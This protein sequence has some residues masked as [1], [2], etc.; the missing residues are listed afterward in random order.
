[1]PTVH[2]DLIHVDQTDRTETNR[3]SDRLPFARSQ[4]ICVL[5]QPVIHHNEFVADHAEP[6]DGSFDRCQHAQRVASPERTIC[7]AYSNVLV[8]YD[9]H[10]TNYIESEPIYQQT[11]LI[12]PEFEHQAYIGNENLIFEYSMPMKESLVSKNQVDQNY[13]KDAPLLDSLVH[14]HPAIFHLSSVNV[15]QPSN[16]HQ[17]ETTSNNDAY[18]SAI[19]P[20]VGNEMARPTVGYLASF[21]STCR[22]AMV[23][24]VKYFL[25]IVSHVE[26]M[27]LF[28]YAKKKN[29]YT[30]INTSVFKTTDREQL[31]EQEETAMPNETSDIPWKA[32]SFLHISR[33]V[34]QW[35][36]YM[37]T[38]QSFRV[39]FDIVHVD[40]EQ[41]KAVYFACLLA[42][43]LAYLI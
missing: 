16:E 41:R 9:E 3:H 13:H 1:M 26:S 39:I 34:S 24:S 27:C 14:E 5:N 21:V 23:R 20:L 4:S 35:N 10:T 2:V 42:A 6:F 8:A 29:V 12:M 40:I 32:S 11:S 17:H 33:T 25:H 31:A 15:Y 7:L 38:I 18:D 36:R 30:Y 22:H 43:F 37:H 19:V 28:L